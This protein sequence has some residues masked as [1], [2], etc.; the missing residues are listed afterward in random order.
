M[1][2]FNIYEDKIT[3]NGA[4][5]EEDINSDCLDTTNGQG[6]SCTQWVIV[7]ENLDY[8]HCKDLEWGKKIKCK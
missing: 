3:P 1:Q 8:L 2:T 7:N 4:G 5:A 6:W